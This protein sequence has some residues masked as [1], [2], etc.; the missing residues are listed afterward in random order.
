LRAHEL[1]LGRGNL[2]VYLIGRSEN[3]HRITAAAADRV[4]HVEGAKRV[5]HEIRARVCHR[6]RHGNLRGKMY[7]R[8]EPRLAEHLLDRP[9]VAD[10]GTREIKRCALAQPS[11]VLISARTR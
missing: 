1:G 6:R 5:G 10:V 11:E 9:A 3:E 7:Y 8:I 4:E 2:S